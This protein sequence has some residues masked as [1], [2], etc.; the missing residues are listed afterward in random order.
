[1]SIA[2]AAATPPRSTPDPA[3]AARAVVPRVRHQARDAA[4]L[5]VFSALTSA[6]VALGFLLLAI[7]AR[8]A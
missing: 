1:M 3:A 8:Q 5:M 7:A 6:G 4:A 2:P